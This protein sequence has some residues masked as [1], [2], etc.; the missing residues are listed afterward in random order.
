MVAPISVGI[1]DDEAF[2]RHA[3][4]SY[5]AAEEDMTI[6]ADATD[7][8]GALRLVARHAPDVLL[9]D[10]QLP[11]FDGIEVTRRL[12]AGDAA[13]RVI[14]V[15]AHVSDRHVIPAL[16]AGAS[17]YIVKDAEPH[18]IIEAIR[19]VADGGQTL[20]PQITRHVLDA[21]RSGTS[22]APSLS[23]RVD[24][25]ARE[26]EVLEALCS[27]CSNAEMASRLHL[28]ESTV[29][30]YLSNLMQKFGSRDRVQLVVA[31]FRSGA[32]R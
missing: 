14:M 4:R 11:D 6:V 19:D 10:L 21:A 3:L 32:V 13:T 29:K 1:V 31:A 27:G 12:V 16:L 17:G 8:E 15:T 26:Q 25:T 23:D 2:V 9:L 20:D 28:A 18:R 7:G 5:L 30:Y 22:T 24:L